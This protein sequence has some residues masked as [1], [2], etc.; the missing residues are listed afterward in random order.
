MNI[1]SDALSYI[2]KAQLSMLVQNNKT[3][4]QKLQLE[5]SHCWKEINKKAYCSILN[6]IV[7]WISVKLIYYQCHLLYLWVYCGNLPS[8][9]ATHSSSVYTP[10]ILLTAM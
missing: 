6:I 3:V 7:E 10:L 4:L 5:Q 2:R 1:L 9:K 8:F